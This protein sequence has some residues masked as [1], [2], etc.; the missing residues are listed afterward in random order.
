VNNILEKYILDTDDIFE[1]VFESETKK[2]LADLLNK[3]PIIQ[4]SEWIEIFHQMNSNS[5]GG[6]INSKEAYVVAASKIINGYAAKN[7]YLFAQDKNEIAFYNVSMWTSLEHSLLKE[8]LK[9]ASNKM[10]IPEYIASSVNF[11]NKLQKQFIQDAYLEKSINKDI[12]YFNLK[13]CTLTL[14]SYGVKQEKHHPKYFLKYILDFEYIINE[15][16]DD[17]LDALK[18]SITSV[19]MQKTFQQAISQ[20]IVKNFRDDRQVCLY[21]VNKNIIDDFIRILKEVIPDDLIVDY[22]KKSN[23]RL[24]DLFINFEDVRKDAKSLEKVIFISFNNSLERNLPKNIYTNKPAVLNW[25][26]DGAKEIIKNRQIY[27]AKECTELKDKCNLVSLF[28][29]DLNLTKTPK[30]SKSIVSTFNSILKQ[31][32][33]FCEL[34][35]EEPLGRGKFNRELKSLGFESTRR[36][37]GNVWFAKFA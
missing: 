25:L 20:I 29:K 15:Q 19:D 3:L 6:K 8:F 31:Y 26:I 32:E 37:S 36:E 35:D 23:A 16:Q 12:S 5:V 28:V 1:E 7:N 2:A 9:T 4:S 13:N 18:S 17:F 33:L 21:G 22:F 24:E 27:I 14:G 11:I 10:G 34:H 30:D